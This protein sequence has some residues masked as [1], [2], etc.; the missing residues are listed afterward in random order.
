M[1]T[2]LRSYERRG[3]LAEDFR[4]FHLRDS[5]LERIDWHYHEF[6]KII[7][8]LGGSAGYSIEGKRYHLQPGDLVLVGRGCIHRPEILGQLLYERIV[9][10]LSPGFLER[11][12][13][14]DCDL[15]LCFR[16]TQELGAHVLRPT[17]RTE[18][19]R[20]SLQALEQD[21]TDDACGAQLLA[22]CHLLEFL[23]QITRDITEGRLDDVSGTDCNAKI[24]SVLQ[25]LNL[26]LTRPITVDALSSQFYIS[27]YHLMR[28]FRDAT[29]YTIHAYLTEKR[30]L[31]ARDR[32]RSGVPVLEACRACGFGDYS[33]FC[34]AYKKRFGSAPTKE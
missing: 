9:L 28:T 17:R 7:L 4:L 18:L 26:N 15:Q 32:I 12:C 16:R 6:H 30:L 29:G 23:V 1:P 21:L 25:Y 11:M 22:Q 24:V 5:S 33:A 27:K 8:L 19:H 31:L 2:D 20:Q 13:T 34:R 10:Y 3:Y 14:P